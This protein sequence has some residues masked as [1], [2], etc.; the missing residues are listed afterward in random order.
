MPKCD[1]CLDKSRVGRL[2]RRAA[3]PVA[4]CV[5][6][7]EVLPAIAT[8]PLLTCLLTAFRVPYIDCELPE[9]FERLQD[10]NHKGE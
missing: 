9:P 4:L 7:T 5:I 10:V 8:L 1:S 6:P 2:E 3:H